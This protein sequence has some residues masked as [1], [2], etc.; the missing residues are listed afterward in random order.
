MR[1]SK[2]RTTITGRISRKAFVL[3][4][5]IATCLPTYLS[6]AEPP[7]SRETAVSFNIPAGD[8]SVALERFSSQS[9]I[10]AM[11]RQ[12]MV[13][14]KRARAVNGSLAPSVSLERL[15]EGT[16][17]ESER[18]NDKTFVLKARKSTDQKKTK[19]PPPTSGTQPEAGGGAASEVSDLEKVVVV[20]SR[21]GAYPAES[22]MPI[23]VISREDIDMSG[24]SNIAQALMYL[25][26]VP[27]NN[28]GD[29]DIGTT[30]PI[31]GSNGGNT[32]S[33]TVQMRGLA[34]GTTLVLINGRRAGESGAYSASGQFDLSAIPLAFVDR[35]EVLPAG[36]SAVYGG[37]GL[38]GVINIVL[39]QD[40]QGTELRVKRY[41]GDGF[42]SNEVSAI[43]GKTWPK[44]NLTIG[45]NW[46]ESSSLMAGERSITAN[47]D[48]RRFGGRDL[49]SAIGYPGTIYS[50]AGCPAPPVACTVPLQD[51]GNLPGLSSSFAGIPVGQDGRNLTPEDFLPTQG[52]ANKTNLVRNLVSNEKIYGVTMSGTL[53]IAEDSELFSEL[54]YSDRTVPAQLVLFS[55]YDGRYGFARSR[56]EASNPYNPFGVPIGI[57]YRLDNTGIYKDFTQ[58]NMRGLLGLRGKL[59]KFDWELSA[60]KSRDKAEISG[61]SSFNQDAIAAALA[62]S[63]SGTALNLF[64]GNG[65]LPASREFLSTLLDPVGYLSISGTEAASGFIKGP[66]TQ[67]KAGSI[68][69]LLGFERT[70]QT[71]E[72]ETNSPS[73]VDKSIDGTSTSN[74]LFGEARVPLIAGKRMGA[75][76]RM[77]ITGAMRLETGDKYEETAK[78]G[79]MGLEFRPVENLLLRSTV[80]SA[81]RPVLTYGAS[82]DPSFQEIGAY[83]SDPRFDGQSYFT[84]SVSQGGIPPGLSPEKST[85]RT[86]GATYRPTEGWS[87]SVTGWEIEIRDRMTGVSSQWL[88]DHEAEFPERIHRNAETGLIEEI[89]SRIINIDSTKTSGV[90]FGVD[91][92]FH[93]SIGTFYPSLAATY[94][95]RYQEKIAARSSV[96]DR[97]ARHST[98]GWAP[99]WKIVPR[100]LWDFNGV[101]TAAL[102]GRYVSAYRDSASLTSGP[103]AGSALT[104]GDFWIADLNV[105]LDINHFMNSTYVRDLRLNIGVNNLFNRLPDFCAGCGVYGYDTSQYDIRGRLFSVE[106]RASF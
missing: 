95:Y 88:V 92:T 53:E 32:N 33:T 43:W 2:T 106:L 28:T 105:G 1:H 60:R 55:V 62:S 90:D 31:S 12:D 76:E 79:A 50:L 80:S 26:E 3:A 10:Q 14:G 71:V 73:L 25:P 41:M 22:A 29:R 104:L 82:E 63:D 72:L 103:S 20:G 42:D 6:A 44:G 75:M 34:K 56:I 40:A 83:I 69:A 67:T 46:K 21:L 78:T 19:S 5:A 70:R 101:G 49:R 45:L 100:L 30:G 54:S 17:L 23:K 47:Q 52:Q 35:I 4:V 85:T 77:A 102:S 93:T 15:L 74:A 57:D 68:D 24:A 39:R 66:V 27:I 11:Y 59:G 89:D 98:S 16:G 84:A 18:V 96:E 86:L 64:A 58:Q 9:G 38:A 48:Y 37:D 81:F 36:S 13:A 94:T 51:R 61:G 7:G 99:R 87:L 91:G 97:V 65:D 8:L